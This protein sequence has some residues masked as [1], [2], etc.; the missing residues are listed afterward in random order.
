[1]KIFLEWLFPQIFCK[2]Y[3]KIN[4]VSIKTQKFLFYCI[5]NHKNKLIFVVSYLDYH[6]TIFRYFLKSLFL[7]F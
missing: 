1:M 4:N 2:T 3:L 6:Q 7:V 5:G